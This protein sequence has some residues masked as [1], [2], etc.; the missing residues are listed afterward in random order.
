MLVFIVIFA[1]KKLD[2]ENFKRTDEEYK[3]LHSDAICSILNGRCANY[4][5]DEW[6]MDSLVD[7][8]IYGADT[9]VKKI[10]EREE[11]T[12]E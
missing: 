9:L 2:M 12:S 1:R 3:R 7:D 11:K 4:S 10:K 5:Y 6:C 8:A